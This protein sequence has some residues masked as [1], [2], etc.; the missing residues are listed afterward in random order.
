MIPNPKNPKQRLAS[1]WEASKQALK[2]PKK[3]L[4]SLINFNKEN[5]PDDVIKKIRSDYISDTV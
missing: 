5:I 3:F 1:Y 2:D 4:E